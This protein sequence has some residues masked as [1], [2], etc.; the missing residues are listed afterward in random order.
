MHTT[1]GIADRAEPP[2][3]ALET[4]TLLLLRLLGRPWLHPGVGQILQTAVLPDHGDSEHRRAARWPIALGHPLN[5]HTGRR[6]N[7]AAPELR[8]G[9]S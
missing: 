9:A 7:R 2:A 6:G 1:Q 5:R 3:Q 4:V 8:S